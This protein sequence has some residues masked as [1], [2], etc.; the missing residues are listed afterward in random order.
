MA[1]ENATQAG[2]NPGAVMNEV[3][4]VVQRLIEGLL[5]GTI[6]PPSIAKAFENGDHCCVQGEAL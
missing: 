2:S 1:D 5:G 3:S 6:V 4:A